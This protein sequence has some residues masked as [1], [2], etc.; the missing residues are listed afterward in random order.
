MTVVMTD[1]PRNITRRS[2]LA[3]SASVAAAGAVFSGSAAGR[4]RDRGHGTDA[5]SLDVNG[6]SDSI[7]IVNGNAKV[8]RWAS[9]RGKTEITVSA[10]SDQSA[11]YTARDFAE[12]INRGIEKGFWTLKRRAGELTFELT[13]KGRQL[14]SE[15]QRRN[16]RLEAQDCGGKNRYEDGVFYFDS[17]SLD[18]IVLGIQGGA[19]IF[20]IASIIVGAL[21]T[22]T[23]GPAIFA[24]AAVLIGLGGTSLGQIDNGCGIKIIQATNEVK[25]QDCDC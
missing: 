14:I 15:Y 22:A 3:S 11:K 17:G 20:T 1:S 2:V 21:T 25:P 10:Q 9:Y 8:K 4:G 18:E 13:E 16:N 6:L 5:K 19:G 24:I 12:D 23:I 7:T